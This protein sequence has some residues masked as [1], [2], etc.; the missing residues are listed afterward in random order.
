MPVLYRLKVP[1]E[2]AG[3]V[4]N[5]HP[6]IKRKV[7]ASLKFIQ[8][9]PYSGKALK[10]ELRDLRSFRVGRFR[11]IYRISTQKVIEIVAVGNRDHIYEETYILIKKKHE[12][13]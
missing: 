8:Q 11:I 12:K 7:R 9:D 10:D 3:L 13:D 1:D 6:H 4:I 5:L 2:V